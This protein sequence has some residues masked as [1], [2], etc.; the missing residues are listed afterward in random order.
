MARRIPSPQQRLIH[1]FEASRRDL[2][3]RDEPRNPYHVW[4]SEVM[5]QQTQ[6]AT[7]IPY[8]RRWL[9]HFPTLQDFAAAPLDD[10]LKLWEGLG[11]YARARNFH[12]AAQTVMHDHGGRIPQTVEGLMQ[13][14]GVGRYTAGAI[15]SLAF[16]QHAPLLDGNVKRVLSRVMALEQVDGDWRLE[17]GDWLINPVS[18][19][20]VAPISHLQS[21]ISP[22]KSADDVLW[23]ISD[24]VLPEGQAGA[25]NEALM[26]LG[27]TVCTPRVPKCDA[28]PINAHCSA[29]A[30]RRQEDFPI[31][32]A[33][34]AAPRNDVLTALLVDSSGRLLMGRRPND[35]LLGGLWEFVSSEFRV[36]SAK[37]LDEIV[38]RRTGLQIDAEAAQLIG[39]VKHSFTHFMMSRQVWLMEHVDSSASLQAN[40]YDELL[41]VSVDE[42]RRLALT[43]SDQRILDLYLQFRGSLFG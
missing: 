18:R 35:G 16:N 40:G 2:P 38:A 25:F 28:C 12:K 8:Y 21:L 30:Q 1:W 39:S 32:T 19:A 11:Y 7:V 31:K 9:E 4:L 23:V 22:L 29:W 27:A 15:A 43:R 36:P 6:V 17:F 20:L 33:K 14:P 3:W 41:W 26:E 24:A 5:L 42:C 34:K 13:L 37:T 10:V